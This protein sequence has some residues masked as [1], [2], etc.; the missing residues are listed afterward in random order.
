MQNEQSK[1]WA[2]AALF[3]TAAAAGLWVASNN[4]IPE[5]CGIVGVVGSHDDAKE[6]LL[7]GLTI[8]QVHGFDAHRICVLSGCPQM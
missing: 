6:F 4:E 1:N 7:E 3:G 2:R 5:S 8:L